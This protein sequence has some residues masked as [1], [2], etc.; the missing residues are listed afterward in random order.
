MRNSVGA[1]KAWTS[2]KGRL[3]AAE[4]PTSGRIRFVPPKNYSP[5]S[6]LTRG[7]QNGYIDRFGN[8]WVRGPSRTAGEAFEWDV[9]LSNRGREMLG[10]LSR[11]GN[12]VNV[13]LGGRV[14]H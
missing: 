12:H 4:L 9:Q 8:E 1:A 3:K 13:S 2:V 5:S 6:P 11:E 7:P 14:T 10:W